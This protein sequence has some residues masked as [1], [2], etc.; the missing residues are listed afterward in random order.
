MGR[1]FLD[2]FH[3][4]PPDKQWPYLCPGLWHRCLGHSVPGHPPQRGQKRVSLVDSGSPSTGSSAMT[5]WT[6]S[7]VCISSSFGRGAGT[8]SAPAER[9]AQKQ[10]MDEQPQV[11][12]QGGAA[13]DQTAPRRPGL[14][15]HLAPSQDFL[16]PAGTCS[17]LVTLAVDGFIF[18]STHLWL[19]QKFLKNVFH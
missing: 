1:Y 13:C 16:V 9:G 10:E 11:W 4:G 19:R 18:T 6:Q 5:R 2:R 8:K 14:L 3:V 12:R 17:T 15:S 7:H